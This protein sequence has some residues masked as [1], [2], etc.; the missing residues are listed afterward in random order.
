M[1][2]L[3]QRVSKLEAAYGMKREGD[4]LLTWP[5]I[6]ARLE[7]GEKLQEL[8]KHGDADV[9]SRVERLALF[10]QKVRARQRRMSEG[11]L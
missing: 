3:E 11:A 6:L 2:D 1:K 9:Q 5:E 7:K 10:M 4:G 8:V